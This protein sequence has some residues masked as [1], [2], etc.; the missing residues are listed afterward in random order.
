METQ[1]EVQMTQTRRVQLPYFARRGNAYYWVVG[2]NQW[3]GPRGHAIYSD[4]SII[5][6]TYCAADA[7]HAESTPI[8]EDEFWAQW[9]IALA[10][11]QIMKGG[12]Q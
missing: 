7:F 1:I 12:E 10:A 2:A 6:N 5:L 3:G 9:N 11:L 4:G 8:T